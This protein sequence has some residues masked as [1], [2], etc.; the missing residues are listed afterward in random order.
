MDDLD[1]SIDAI[2]DLMGVHRIAALE[3]QLAKARELLRHFTKDSINCGFCHRLRVDEYGHA[4]DC[5]LAAFLKE[6][7]DET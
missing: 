6:A 1:K 5:R 2:L 4:A 3:S 7:D